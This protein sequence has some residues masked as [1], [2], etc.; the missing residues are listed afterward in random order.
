[1]KKT[2]TLIFAAWLFAACGSITNATTDQTNPVPEETPPEQA[3]G[4]ESSE[5]YTA[6][7]PADSAIPLGDTAAVFNS[8]WIVGNVS[9]IELANPTDALLAR[10]TTDGSDAV[11]R[12]AGGR[13]Y[14]LNRFGTDT[15]QVINPSDF[16][17][18]GNYSV[19]KNSNPQDI[20]VVSDD[21]A[22]ISR[23]DSQADAENTDDV[24][25]V[26][27]ISGALLG[28]IDLKPYTTDDGDRLA[29]AAQMVFVDG[30]VY[31][32][33]QDLPSNLADPADTNGKVAIIDSETDEIVDADPETPGIQVVELAGRNPSDMTYS[34]LTDK[35]YV[36]N[37][38]PYDPFPTVDTSSAFG[39][40]EVFRRDGEGYVNEGIVVDDADLGGGVN[41]V[42]IAS[43]S[44][45]YTITNST[46]VAAFNPESYEVVDVNVYETPGFFLPDFTIDRNGR[47]LVAEQDFGGP[48]VV[49]L[50]LN[51]A[52]IAGPTEVGAPPASITFVDAK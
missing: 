15:V 52:V 24:I 51:G 45:G 40:I 8:D 39:G 41:E 26:N 30:L 23:L 48:G 17:V 49:F 3:E 13:I 37:T 10:I 6:T 2:L 42:R 43:A 14:A 25:I 32:C 12:S 35:F 19:G 11:L 46:T 34:P 4:G 20:V 36:A 33:M 47:I 50:D 5:P 18:A 1:M 29:R 21:K 28:S 7:H 44:L 16:T 9:T 38:G 31:V 27:P 22:Y